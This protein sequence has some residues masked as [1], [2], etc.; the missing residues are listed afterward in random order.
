MSAAT[1]ASDSYRFVFYSDAELVL[2]Q[3]LIT[4]ARVKN[5]SCVPKEVEGNAYA[6][7]ESI[8]LARKVSLLG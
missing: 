5:A 6:F 1:K 7:P 8:V 4:S 3:D 2:K